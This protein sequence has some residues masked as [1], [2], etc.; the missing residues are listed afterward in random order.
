MSLR[1]PLL[2]R[3]SPYADECLQILATAKDAMPSDKWLCQLVKAQHIGEDIGVEFSMDD[4]ASVLSLTDS[5]TQRALRVFEQQLKEW[6]GTGGEIMQSPIMKHTE[7]II[8]LYMHEIAMHHNHNIDDFRPP[9]NTTPI[10]GPPD[11]DLITP[12]HT[13]SLTAC[14]RSAH[15][16]FESF[17][18]MDIKTLRALPTHFFVRNSYAAVALIKLYSAVTAKGSKFGPM[19]PIDDL[20]VDHYLDRLIQTLTKVSENGMS[21]V[22]YKFKLIFTMLRNW[23]LKR[24]E[25]PNGSGPRDSSQ[26]QNGSR[27]TTASG[28]NPTMLHGNNTA[29]AW[30]AQPSISMD[31]SPQSQPQ[32]QQQ[33]RSGLQML[34]DAA[35][36]PSAS[37]NPGQ[38]QNQGQTGRS[39]L[40]P[41][42]Q[43]L[44]PQQQQMGQMQAA[45]VMNPHPHSNNMN[46]QMGGV[47][48]HHQNQPDFNM[49]AAAYGVSADQMAIGGFTSDDFVSF[50]LGDDWMNFGFNPGEAHGLW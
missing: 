28:Y 40:P 15:N 27:T 29:S 19:F 36:G 49:M 2:I 6:Y 22:A 25:S 26:S 24:T 1:R 47:Q 31:R 33:P 42:G 8:N 50:G 14:L 5:K 30:S 11:P 17:L 43:W 41:Q 10:E 37:S 21:R 35:M 4:P 7:A 12:A 38:N 44:T 48:Q 13:E 3:W 18:S 20:K 39:N 34:S 16:A 9:F 23:H 32:Q 46:D 45:T